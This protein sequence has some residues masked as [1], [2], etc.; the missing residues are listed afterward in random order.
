VQSFFR[1][2]QQYVTTLEAQQ[3]LEVV[4]APLDTDT[5]LNMSEEQRAQLLKLQEETQRLG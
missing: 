5:V 1:E 2:W 4:G 3:T